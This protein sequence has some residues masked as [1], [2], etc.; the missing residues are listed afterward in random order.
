MHDMREIGRQIAANFL[1]NS[2]QWYKIAILGFLVANP[3]ILLVFGPFITGWLILIEFI[4]T[5]TMALRCYPLAPGGLIAIEAVLL[6]MTS[7]ANVFHEVENNFEV[8]MLLVF[9]VAGVFFLSALRELQR[10]LPEDFSHKNLAAS[11]QVYAEEL[12]VGLVAHW[13][14]ETGRTNVALAGGVC[15]NVKINQRVHEIPG[16]ESVYVHPGMPDDGMPVGAALGLY[17]Q[18]SEQAYRPDPETMPHVYLGPDYDDDEVKAE[19]ERQEVPATHC[20]DIESQVARLLADG[21]IVARFSGRM[22]YGPRALGNRTILYQPT[23][24]S[25]T[26]WLN[27]V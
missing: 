3:I 25:V 2:P 13:L 14:A 26:Y 18:L 7:P 5:L 1:G 20:Y 8:I 4:F 16:V 21:A 15:S 27:D 6:G 12:V 22:E 19:L 24:P 17:H 9:M 11:V 23:D 10:R